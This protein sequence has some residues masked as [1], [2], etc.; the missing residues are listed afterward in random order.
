LTIRVSSLR[1]ACASTALFASEYAYMWFLSA[2]SKNRSIVKD[3]AV[4]SLY[5]KYNPV[6]PSVKRGV[7][8]LGKL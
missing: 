2:A 3:A 1:V 7:W 5:F 4:V 8:A 6:V